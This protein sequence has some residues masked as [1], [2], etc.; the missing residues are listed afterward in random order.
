MLNFFNLKKYDLW[1]CDVL[2]EPCG[3]VI[4]SIPLVA[5]LLMQNHKKTTDIYFE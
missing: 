1:K 3:K 5:L 2:E 4:G